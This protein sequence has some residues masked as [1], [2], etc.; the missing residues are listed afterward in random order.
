MQLPH[1]ISRASAR[2]SIEPALAA[3]WAF[4]IVAAATA[5]SFNFV[6]FMHA[7]DLVIAVGLIPALLLQLCLR[8][9]PRRGLTAL[10]P[11]WYGWMVWA[12]AGLFTAR[13]LSYHAETA[14]RYALVLFAASLAAETFLAGRRRVW[15]Y[16][17]LI[18]SGVATGAL[19]LLQYARLID[20]LLPPFPGYDQRAY[21]VFA[22]QNLLGGYMAI[23]LT[24]F[25]V[26]LARAGRLP[27]YLLSLYLCGWAI[28]L[29]ALLVSATRTA[30]LAAMVG[31]ACIVI[32]LVRESGWKRMFRRWRASGFIIILVVAVLLLLVAAPYVYSRLAVSYGE[33]DVGGRAR[34]WFWAG[35]AR[36]IRDNVLFGVGLGNYNYWSPWYQGLA[37]WAPGGEQF[38]HNELHTVHAH[39]EPLEW[40]AE[41]GVVGVL[42]ILWFILSVLR[43]RNPA[44]PALAAFAVFACFN[45]VSHST[46]HLLAGLLLATV[47]PGQPPGVPG[48]AGCAREQQIRGTTARPV[49]VCC[50]SGLF[51]LASGIIV[52]AAFVWTTLVPSA[53]LC[54]A[55]Q[56]HVGTGN[57]EPQYR[58]ALAW[59][60]PN[61]QAH[62]SYAIALLDASRF[63][64]AQAQLE[65]A[66]YGMDTGRVHLLLAICAEACGDR[67]GVAHHAR[68]CLQRWPANAH[69]WSLAISTAPPEAIAGLEAARR[70]FVTPG[71]HG[72]VNILPPADP[73]NPTGH[74]YPELK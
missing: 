5:W 64:E 45:T 8:G 49:P 43:K 30:W 18:I 65:A 10:A 39:S 27:R 25:T 41:T 56:I 42:F 70:R 16:R 47:R 60:W 17:A 37:L 52:V 66:Q 29:G 2:V 9:M 35:A 51:A 6:S 57:P 4:L 55:E 7:K 61:P 23:T 12:V 33:A 14:I 74:P 46:P 54:R 26:L 71:A 48:V 50:R 59:P 1:F 73:A 44:L 36:M 21:S 20:P 34:L 19:A 15:L 22:N 32:T 58:R 68:N 24:L 63:S 38:Y 72:D 62:A 69:A 40:L 13:V 53:L 28:L 11:L 31:C 3:L 67:R